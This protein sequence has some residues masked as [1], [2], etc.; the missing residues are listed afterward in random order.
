M[1]LGPFWSESGYKFAHFG[2]E[3]GV[4]FKGTMAVYERTCIY[5]INTNEIL[6]ELSRKKLDIFTC[7]N[8]M[9]SSHVKILYYY[10]T[11]K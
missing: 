3:L 1:V 5:Y 11:L 6:G 8:N 2:L 4:V 7:E 10:I 9:L